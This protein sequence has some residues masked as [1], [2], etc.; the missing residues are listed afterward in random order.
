VEKG[1]RK[2]YIMGIEEAPEYSKESLYYAHANEMNGRNMGS[3]NLS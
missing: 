1:G 3:G 2:G